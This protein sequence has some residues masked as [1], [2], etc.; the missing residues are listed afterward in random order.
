MYTELARPSRAGPY[1]SSIEVW[2]AVHEDWMNA[3]IEGS[4][5]PEE[6]P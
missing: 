2:Y 5:G 4:Q 6:K 3:Q 1:H